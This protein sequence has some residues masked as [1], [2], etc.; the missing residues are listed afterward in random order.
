M[1]PYTC[2]MIPTAWKRVSMTTRERASKAAKARAESLT[3]ERR[4]DI[5]RRAAR[6]RHAAASPKEDI[7]RPEYTGTLEIGEIVLPCAVL[8]NRMRVISEASVARQL[9]RGT[10][11]KARKLNA[12]SGGPPMPGFLS[13]ATLEPFVPASLRL[14]LSE[15][16]VFRGRGGQRRGVEATLLPEI[17]EAWLKAR[18][19]GVLQ[20]QQFRIAEKADVL[21]R[22]LAHVGITALVDEATGYQEIR[23]RDELHGVLEA[24]VAKELLPW[25]KRFPDEFYRQLFRLRG[26]QYSPVSVKR[27]KTVGRIMS[28]LIYEKLPDGVIE[29]LRRRNPVVSDHG[30]R[31]HR[32]LQFF[33][34]EVGHPHLDRHIASV[35]ALMRAS[36]SWQGFKRLFDRAFPSPVGQEELPGILEQIDEVGGNSQ[37]R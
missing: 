14:A 5:A 7:P 9:G 8:P 29:E 21:M 30:R 4:R 13:D 34:D 12:A 31:R 26:W 16:V 10:G 17:C 3:P 22:A 19:A 36:S 37:V 2:L 27:P 28:E 6:A 18:D 11:G 20:P 32:Q 1:E 25:A 15:P 24:Y 35:T 23:D 33:A